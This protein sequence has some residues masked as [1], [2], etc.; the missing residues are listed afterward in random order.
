MMGFSQDIDEYQKNTERFR[1]ANRFVSSH[2][3]SFFVDL[4]RKIKPEDLKDD[5]TKEFF[6]GASD[7]AMMFT[8]LELANPKFQ[9]IP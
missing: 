5:D 4:F 3:K 1:M 8:M 9:Y 2:L 6:G 7:T